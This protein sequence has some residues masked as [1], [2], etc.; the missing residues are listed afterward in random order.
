VIKKVTVRKRQS[1]LMKKKKDRYQMQNYSHAQL[2]KR[3]VTALAS[4]PWAEK[5]AI[6]SANREFD[7]KIV[8]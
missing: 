6:A 5:K 7:V 1:R 2:D 4:R 3:T 8:G